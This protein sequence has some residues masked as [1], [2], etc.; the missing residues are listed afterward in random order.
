MMKK[1]RKDRKTHAM[2]RNRFNDINK[3]RKRCETLSYRF[4]D[5]IDGQHCCGL[6]MSFNVFQAWRHGV[7]A[8]WH[9]MA[10]PSK[11]CHRCHRCHRCRQPRPHPRHRSA[12]AS[13][14]THGLLT[15]WDLTAQRS[16]RHILVSLVSSLTLKCIE[17]P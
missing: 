14:D 2:C 15:P 12:E 1:C 16:S 4:C 6:Y 8:S 7:M 3:P 11:R 13:H 9:L 10:F 5:R 17:H